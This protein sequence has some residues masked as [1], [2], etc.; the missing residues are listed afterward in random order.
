[1]LPILLLL[2]LFAPSCCQ[3]AAAPKG[4]PHFSHAPCELARVI[5][6]Y[7]VFAQPCECASECLRVCGCL[8][9]C[10]SVRVFV[11]NTFFISRFCARIVQTLSASARVAD[12]V[13]F[14]MQNHLLSLSLSLS[15]SASLHFVSNSQLVS[16]RAATCCSWLNN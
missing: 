13:C 2:L 11:A 6:I 3:H 7:F 5:F 9:V 15:L 4:L 8:C 16:P 1:M 14:D 10:A 12:S